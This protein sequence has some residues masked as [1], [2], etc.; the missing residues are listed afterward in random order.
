M[1][2]SF[3]YTEYLY[4]LL[5]YLYMCLFKKI[6]TIPQIFSKAWNKHS[7]NILTYL[8]TRKLYNYVE[9]A[10]STF[11]LMMSQSTVCADCFYYACCRAGQLIS[12]WALACDIVLTISEEIEKL[13]PYPEL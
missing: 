7:S 12:V 5:P 2:R 11:V 10:I 6:V 3:D 9:D 1:L 13:A 4:E 8:V